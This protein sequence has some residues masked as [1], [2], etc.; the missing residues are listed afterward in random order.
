[1]YSLKIIETIIH[2]A[3]ESY[4]FIAHSIT[5]IIQAAIAFIALIFTILHYR[6]EVIDKQK[7]SMQ[8]MF[9]R[10]IMPL[11]KTISILLSYTQISKAPL[12]P[13]DKLFIFI[14]NTLDEY[15]SYKREVYHFLLQKSFSNKFISNFFIKLDRLT[16]K[17]REHEESYNKMG[18]A[19]DMHGYWKNYEK[20]LIPLID[21]F[22]QIRIK[23][24]K[25]YGTK[26]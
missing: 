14:K 6:S 16:K 1:M 4:K 19:F 9:D 8:D 5:T 18:V 21:D 22:R 3:L 12:Y 10:F 23:L 11:G 24:F 26:I 15:D 2:I 25:K 7:A 13:S 20:E 17:V